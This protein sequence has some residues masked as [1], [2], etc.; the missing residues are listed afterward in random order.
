MTGT[1]SDRHRFAKKT[2]PAFSPSQVARLVPDRAGGRPNAVS[3]VDVN[4]LLYRKAGGVVV[5]TR[6]PALDYAEEGICETAKAA[7]SVRVPPWSLVTH[8]K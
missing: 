7:D 8:F 2:R 3:G 6:G 1:L 5:A 4:L